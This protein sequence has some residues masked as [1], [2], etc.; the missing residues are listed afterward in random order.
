MLHFIP[1]KNIYHTNIHY[2]SYRQKHALNTLNVFPC[3][4]T[5]FVQHNALFAPKKQ[6]FFTFSQKNREKVWSYR[7]NN[8]PLQPHFAQRHTAS[9]AQLVRAP[10]C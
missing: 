3:K 2:N 9:V 8:L 5:S 7:K 10:D 4:N 1:T 6:L